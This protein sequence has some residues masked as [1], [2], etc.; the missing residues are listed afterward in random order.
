MDN[1]WVKLHRKSMEST[2]WKNP[3]IWFVWSWCLMKANHK[4]KKFPFNGKDILVK[5]GS[6]ITG[7]IKAQEELPTL[8]RQN[9]R[10]AFDYLKSTNRITIASTNKFSVITIVNWKKYQQ[11]NPQTNQ[12]L[13]NEQPATNQPL[14][15]NKNVKKE[16]NVKKPIIAEA[17]SAFSYKDY[18]QGMEDDDRRHINVIGH[19]FEEKGLKFGSA[20]EMSAAI[21]RHLRAAVEVAKFTDDKIVKATNQAKREYKDNYTVETILKVLTR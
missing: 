1:G 17:S 5:N 18:L 16:K 12:P 6:F 14:T 20:A 8:T 13:T 21:K 10:T 9:I 19:Y 7:Q 3:M 4:D 2:I 15:T 11:D